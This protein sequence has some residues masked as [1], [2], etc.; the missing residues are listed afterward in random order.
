[1]FEDENE[2]ISDGGMDVSDIEDEAPPA[3]S[4]RGTIS[5]S[6]TSSAPKPPQRM[7]PQQSV[8]NPPF[9]HSNV[10]R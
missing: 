5:H 2:E 9:A 7:R 10:S 3:I 1:M 8:T 6:Q 4:S